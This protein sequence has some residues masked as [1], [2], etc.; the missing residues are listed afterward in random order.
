MKIIKNRRYH[1]LICFIN[2]QLWLCCCSCVVPL[3]QRTFPQHPVSLKSPEHVSKWSSPAK[4]NFSSLFWAALSSP[5]A[6]PLCLTGFGTL[7]TRSWPPRRPSCVSCW[8]AGCWKCRD[9][10]S[11]PGRSPRAWSLRRWSSLPVRDRAEDEVR[12]RVGR[13]LYRL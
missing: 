7:W 6:S 10:W 2:V 12:Q 1:V 11:S 5:L 8:A 4:I 13:I 9:L 3:F